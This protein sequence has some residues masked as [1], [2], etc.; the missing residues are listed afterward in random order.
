MESKTI[1]KISTCNEGVTIEGNLES[2]LMTRTAQ[3]IGENLKTDEDGQM[4]KLFAFFV[5]VLEAAM[6][7]M[8]PLNAAE[9]MTRVMESSDAIR[10]TMKNDK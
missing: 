9:F 10:E 8:T 4:S 3:T 1:L 7:N 2:Q 5:M 6:A